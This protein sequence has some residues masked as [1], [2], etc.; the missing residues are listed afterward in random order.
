MVGGRV[1]AGLVNGA[2]HMFRRAI[3]GIQAQRL[4]AGADHIVAC[5]LGHDDPIIRLDLVADTIDPDFAFA[6]L[7]AEELV[8][9]VV[10]FLS[11]FIAGLDRHEDKLEVMPGV[12]YA[13]E[14]V[15]FFRQLFDVV[16]ETLHPACSCHLTPLLSI[17]KRKRMSPGLA[18]D[19]Q[20]PR[21]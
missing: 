20:H 9:V 3:D 8:P 1:G 12:Q 7:D 21:P 15:V 18:D 10:D 16:D 6:A 5:A 4:L 14:I 13:A 17:L 2:V 11:D 19:P